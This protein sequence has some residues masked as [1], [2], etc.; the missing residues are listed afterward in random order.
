MIEILGPPLCGTF[1]LFALHGCFWGG[2]IEL[3]YLFFA[4]VFGFLPSC[5]YSVIMELWIGLGYAKRFGFAATVA[6]STCLGLVTGVIFHFGVE[7][8]DGYIPVGFITGLLLG[9][10]LASAASKVIAERELNP[11]CGQKA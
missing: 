8:T 7:R 2:G 10:V 11:D 6:L 4:Y 3:I 1:V 9:I 5:V